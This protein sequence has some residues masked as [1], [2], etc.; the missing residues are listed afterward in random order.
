MILALVILICDAGLM[1]LNFSVF[2]GVGG[3]S[4]EHN[5][6]LARLLSHTVQWLD[7]EHFLF[8]DR[9]CSLARPFLGRL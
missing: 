8:H 4:P 9:S 1:S 6:R 3:K 7:K 5:R 2:K